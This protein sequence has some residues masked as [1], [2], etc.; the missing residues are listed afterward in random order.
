MSLKQGCHMALG[1]TG[2]D[3]RRLIFKSCHSTCGNTVK[4]ASF[5]LLWGIKWV[6]PEYKMTFPW[7]PSHHEW[8]RSVQPFGRA[9]RQTDRHEGSITDMARPVLP[10][11]GLLVDHTAAPRR[12][13]RVL[14]D[15]TEQHLEGH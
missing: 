9:D 3:R 14:V 15:R 10:L 11:W 6:T 1:Q 13:K 7:D 8:C 5:F 12:S 2:N 4:T